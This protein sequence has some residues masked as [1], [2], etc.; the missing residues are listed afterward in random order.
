MAFTQKDFEAQEQ[1]LQTLKD[2]LSRLDV[3]FAAHLKTLGLTEADLKTA[4][5]GDIPPDVQQMMSEAMD[6][7]KREG[8][9]RSAQSSPAASSGGKAPGA[10]R[11]GAV[12]L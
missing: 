12:R 10:G 2:E 8:Q 3:Q 11:R 5:E 4:L 9:A 1:Q 7:A 6:K